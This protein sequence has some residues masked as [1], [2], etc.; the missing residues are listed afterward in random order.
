MAR[1]HVCHAMDCDKD[2]PRRMLMC[3]PHWF[4]LPKP[5]RDAIWATYQPGQELGLVRPSAE[6]IANV[7]TA[8]GIVAEK[9]G[10]QQRLPGVE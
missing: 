3:K 7:R 9:E 2:V 6:Y 4:M 10:K 8:V 1:R 5:M